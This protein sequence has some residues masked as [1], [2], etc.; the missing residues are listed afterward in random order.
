[1]RRV[2]R[3][4]GAIMNAVAPTTVEVEE[5]HAKVVAALTTLLEDA[6]L[7]AEC[8]AYAARLA[9]RAVKLIGVSSA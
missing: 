7:E 1:M 5:A 9:L 8:G 2:E 3:F 6:K 4:I